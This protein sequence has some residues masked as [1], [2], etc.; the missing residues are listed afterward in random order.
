MG[1]IRSDGEIPI[2]PDRA[3]SRA[4]DEAPAN[5]EKSAQD[6]DQKSNRSQIDRADMRVGDRKIHCLFRAAPAKESEQPGGYA[7]EE[8]GLAD[9]QNDG[10]QGVE[11]YVI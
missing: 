6:A 7:L 10:G 11:F 5:S 8:N 1:Q 4:R 2:E 3:Q 9:D